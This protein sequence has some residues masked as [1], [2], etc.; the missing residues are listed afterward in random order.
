[1]KKNGLRGPFKF[2]ACLNEFFG[3]IRGTTFYREL[4]PPFNFEF[5]YKSKRI[6][7]WKGPFEGVTPAYDPW[8]FEF[9]MEK[10]WFQIRFNFWMYDKGSKTFKTSLRVDI[11]SRAELVPP[12]AEPDWNFSGT[13]FMND[14]RLEEEKL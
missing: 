5:S 11:W 4:F 12:L 10:Y 9:L 8:D 13:V 3:I 2:F 7:N 1:M 6:R 14:I